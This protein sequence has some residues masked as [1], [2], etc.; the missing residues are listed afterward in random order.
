MITRQVKLVKLVG[1]DLSGEYDYQTLQMC[2]ASSDWMELSEEDYLFLNC[3]IG[4]LNKTLKYGYGKYILIENVTEEIPKNIQEIKYIIE[5]EQKRIDA[6]KKKALE[7]TEKR[8]QTLASK[9][10]EKLLK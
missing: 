9:R 10:K 8:K 2:C 5:K 7:R 1:R 6:D 4:Y 3:N